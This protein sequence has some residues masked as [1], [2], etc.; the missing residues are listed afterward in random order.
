MTPGK[1]AMEFTD[2]KGAVVEALVSDPN[3]AAA[4][5]AP[6]IGE[7]PPAPEDQLKGP[8]GEEDVDTLL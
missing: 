4:L 8:P 2:N 5:E 3:T 6:S 7:R 1:T